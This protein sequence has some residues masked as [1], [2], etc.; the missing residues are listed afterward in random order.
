ME[1]WNIATRDVPEL[2]GY[3]ERIERSD[4]GPRIG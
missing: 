1:I 3:I 2:L 4:P